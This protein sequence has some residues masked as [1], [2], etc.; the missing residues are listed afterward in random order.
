MMLKMPRAVDMKARDVGT[1]ERK[2][3]EKWRRY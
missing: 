2:A 3:E 1:H